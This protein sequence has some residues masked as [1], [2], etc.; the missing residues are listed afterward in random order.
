MGTS[1]KISPLKTQGKVEIVRNKL[2][3]YISKNLSSGDKLPTVRELEK[4]LEVSRTTV[5]S[6]LSGLSAEK[7]ITA[8]HGSGYFVSESQPKSQFPKHTV[9]FLYH[10]SPVHGEG[11]AREYQMT[12]LIEGVQQKCPELNFRLL[13]FSNDNFTY[14]PDE[15]SH[16]TSLIVNGQLPEGILNYLTE[17]KVP[18]I[19][20]NKTD[21]CKSGKDYTIVYD[22]TDTIRAFLKRIKE[23]GHHNCGIVTYTE[24]PF[25]Q[26][27]KFHTEI[28]GH[29]P[30]NEQLL[31]LTKPGANEPDFSRIST[32]LT[33]TDKIPDA[34]LLVDEY[35]TNFFLR[36][37]LKLGLRIPEDIS[38]VCNYYSNTY[39]GISPVNI[40]C[41]DIFS[42]S[43]KLGNKTGEILSAIISDNPPTTHKFKLHPEVYWGE[44][45][46]H[47]F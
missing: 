15:L 10:N 37:C 20:L 2:R 33:N 46:S 11:I 19:C 36:E 35:I 28:F 1:N 17:S 43:R 29:E 9:G 26:F 5:F 44:S 7:F 18:L 4:Y 22:N 25:T 47:T 40:T 41:A 13:P 30:M 16:Y 42:Y 38:I 21:E 34:W 23:Y 14:N 39:F 6:A 24:K 45:I 8:V 3:E 12:M 27:R 31:L 32:L